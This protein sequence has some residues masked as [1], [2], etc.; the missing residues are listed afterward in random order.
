MIISA[1][2]VLRNYGT[3]SLQYSTADGYEPLR[4]IIAE[5]Y[6]KFGLDIDVND[7]LITTGSQQCLDLIAKV[8]LDKGDVVLVENPTHLVALQALVFLKLFLKLFLYVM[9]ELIWR[10]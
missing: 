6:V 5:R 4:E 1:N 2:N 9:M 3:D 8:F 7:I 10:N